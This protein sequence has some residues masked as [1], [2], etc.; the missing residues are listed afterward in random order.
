[1]LH[2]VRGNSYR[3]ARPP[4][5]GLF[6]YKIMEKSNFTQEPIDYPLTAR[7]EMERESYRKYINTEHKKERWNSLSWKRKMQ[8]TFSINNF[9]KPFW[10]LFLAV[11][12]IYTVLH[13][14]DIEPLSQEDYYE[15]MR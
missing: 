8:V 10:K 5:S 9:W 15:L 14:L 11:C 12:V 3:V 7:T 6:V 2:V 1:M 4:S 13:V